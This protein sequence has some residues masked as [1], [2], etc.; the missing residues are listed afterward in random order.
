MGAN[1]LQA[2]IQANNVRSLVLLAGFPLLLL[3]I[4]YA[5]TFA[6]IGGGYLLLI[7]TLARSLAEI[8]IPLGILTAVVG[9]PVFIWLLVSSRRSWS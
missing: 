1:G 3:G 5:F 8:E 7:D 2:H 9:T 6:L 4:V